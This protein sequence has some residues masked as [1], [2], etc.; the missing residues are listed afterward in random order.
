MK[1]SILQMKSQ[2]KTKK[3]CEPQCGNLPAQ[4]HLPIPI[5]IYCEGTKLLFQEITA[6]LEGSIQHLQLPCLANM[7][8]EI[9]QDLRYL[10]NGEFSLKQGQKWSTGHSPV[11]RVA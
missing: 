9:L 1:L 6:S 8:D 4:T 5:Y 3:Q 11:L 7:K 2:L 10:R